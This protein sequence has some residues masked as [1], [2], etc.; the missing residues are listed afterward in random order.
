MVPV[1]S[2]ASGPMTRLAIFTICSANYLP[3]ARVFLQSVAQYHPEASRFLCLVERTANAIDVPAEIV[4]LDQL[5]ID[6][7]DEFTFRYD[8][9]EL[10]TAAKPFMFNHLFDACGFDRV[11]YFDPDIALY[12]PLAGVLRALDEGASLALT[13]HCCRPAEGGVI[14]DRTIM[15][16]GVFNLGFLA[17]SRGA[18]ASD[19]LHWWARRLRFDC[20]ADP[21]AG[22]FVDQK[23]MDLV[24]G[25]A[26]RA[27]ILHDTSLN[28]A[29]WNLPQRRLARSEAGWTIDGAP[30]G[31]FHFSGVDPWR[32][33]RLSKYLPADGPALKPAMQA[34]LDFYAARLRAAGFARSPAPPYAFGRFASG[35][36][37]APLIRRM[38]RECHSLWPDNPFIG[39]EAVLQ[40][41]YAGASLEAAPYVVTNLLHYIYQQTHP[42]PV[43]HDLRKADYVRDLVTWFVRSAAREFSLDER[44]V[45]PVA[46]RIGEAR[47][48]RQLAPEAPGE[49]TGIDVT[50]V[51]YFG[52][53]SGVG[54]AARLTLGSLRSLP[55]IRSEGLDVELNVSGP[56]ESVEGLA[57]VAAGRVQLFQVNADQLPLVRAA[58]APRLRPSAYR[59]VTPFWE[60]S[61]LPAGWRGAFEGI[62][63]VWAPSR[64][65]QAML[66]RDLDLPVLHMP[67]ALD[68]PELGV[69]GAVISP[70]DRFGFP[71]DCFLF[72]FAFDFLSFPERKNPSAAIAAFRMAFGQAGD[73]RV[74]LAIKTLNGARAPAALA[75]LQAGIAGDPRIVLVDGAVSRQA[76]S[77]MTAGCD[78]LLSLHRSEGF[79]LLVAE[80]MMLCRPVIA[81]D[82]GAT[83]ELV[84]PA[85]GF[86]VD[87]RLI[88]VPTGDYPFPEDQVWADPDIAHAAWLMQRVR[89]DPAF[90]RGAVS[91]ARIM[92][93]QRHGLRPVAARQRARLRELGLP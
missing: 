22:L 6:D 82:Y 80:A 40:E 72:F 46:Q 55:D 16:K 5:G 63:E 4:L 11:L 93:E 83:T 47:R 90:S 2:S 41:P 61:R 86:A 7:L 28:V 27:R 30:L 15:Q 58:L 33:D 34:L 51:G 35:T 45:A 56:R 23:F 60:L 32:T 81:T 37:I 21:A 54:E 25:F 62:D 70:D 10:N 71:L 20:V 1:E 78:C 53:T 68:V 50:V 14:D 88:P 38:F 42:D 8:V 77:R 31:F 64:F 57:V 52:S 19:I 73:G 12:A 67:P 18:E 76:M 17:A 29:Y 3:M 91:A 74:A 44:L 69:D 39:Y 9:M 89:A 92:L 75:A 87:C 49:A 79:G 13:P 85:T 59:I 65:I 24:P 26:P 43:L 36:P 66:V 84:T 48:G